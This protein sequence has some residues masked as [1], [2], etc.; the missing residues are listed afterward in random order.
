MPR[1]LELEKH[2]TAESNGKNH[3]DA[4]TSA[5]GNLAAHFLRENKEKGR[6]LRI[7]RLGIILHADGSEEKIKDSKTDK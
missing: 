1:K 6:S 5:V 3:I 7:P 4:V 2:Q